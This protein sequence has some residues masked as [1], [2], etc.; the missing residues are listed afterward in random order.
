MAD[1]IANSGAFPEGTSVV[2]VTVSAPSCIVELSGQAIT[3]SF[4]DDVADSMVDG[5]V[6]ALGDFAD[7]SEI[8]VT[9][10]GEPLWKYVPQ[11]TAPT[12]GSGVGILS[13]D[14]PLSGVVGVL[15]AQDPSASPTVA[16]LSSELAGK[17]VVLGPSHGAYASATS[18]YRAMRTFCGPNPSP[19]R[20]TGWTGSTYL[21]SNYYYWD[22]GF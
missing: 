8:E 6:D 4:G 11:S 9:V 17:L 7:I 13:T 14:S 2:S 15:S 22:K 21:P 18:W 19:P 20:P 5:I 10:A 3:P 16:P 12:V 1:A